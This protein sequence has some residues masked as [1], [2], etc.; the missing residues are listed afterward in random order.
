MCWVYVCNQVKHTWT[1]VV[2]SASLNKRSTV[3]LR[4]ALDKVPWEHRAH[5]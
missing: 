4:V 3:T 1:L 5:E 2:N